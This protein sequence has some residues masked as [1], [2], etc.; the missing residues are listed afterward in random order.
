MLNS[1]GAVLGS[2]VVIKTQTKSVRI[3]P[4]AGCIASDL[5]KRNYVKHLI[6]RYNE[7][8]QQQRDRAFRYQAVYG[9]IQRQFGAKWD[10]V[11]LERFQD[12]STFVQRKIDSTKLGRINRAKGNRNYS[13]Y[14][15][16]RLKYGTQEHPRE[17]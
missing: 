15:D 1:P 13:K 2:T 8:A 9:S 10:M 7:F 17:I 4:P 5:P 16:F 14:D 12:L 3:G 11:P 6:D